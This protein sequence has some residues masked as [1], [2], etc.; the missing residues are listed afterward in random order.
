[1]TTMLTDFQVDA[2]DDPVTKL[3]IGAHELGMDSI[4]GW[5]D[6]TRYNYENWA[7]VQPNDMDFY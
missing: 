3:W 2:Q 7:P 5:S 4:W 1:M 6:E